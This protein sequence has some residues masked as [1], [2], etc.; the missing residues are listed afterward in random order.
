MNTIFTCWGLICGLIFG[1]GAYEAYNPSTA[2]KSDALMGL[3][4][5]P[6]F[7][8][9]ILFAILS[10]MK[11]HGDDDRGRD[12]PSTIPDPCPPGHFLFPCYSKSFE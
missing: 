3:F 2:L 6:F 10:A 12:D 11:N 7:G 8:T 5:F 1:Y 4:L 9:V